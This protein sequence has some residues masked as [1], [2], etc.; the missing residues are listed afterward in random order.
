MRCIETKLAGVLILEPDVYPDARG[1]F[2]EHYN[3]SRYAELPG[4]DVA[5]V[6]DNHSHSMHGVLRGLHLQRE[7][8][9]GKLVTALRGSIWDVA[10]DIDPTSPTFRAWVGV[11]LTQHNHRQIYIPPGYAHGFC[12]LSESADLF[13]KCTESRHAGDE[14]GIAW[15]DPDLAIAWPVREPVLSTKDA[16]NP[17]LKRY[18]QGLSYPN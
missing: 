17:S 11:E 16:A 8:P 6:Q 5:F 3:R 14:Y 18:L 4:L 15:N 9:Q 13:Y 12:V 7:H 2:L 10:V 1:F